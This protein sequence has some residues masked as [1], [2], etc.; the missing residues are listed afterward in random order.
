MGMFGTIIHGVKGVYKLI[1]GDSDIANKELD[2]AIDCLH[3][4]VSIDPLGVGD[5]CDVISD[6]LSDKQ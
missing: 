3:R 5:L 1:D 4:T 2:K 6:A